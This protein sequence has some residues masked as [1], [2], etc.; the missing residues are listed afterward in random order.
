M[1]WVLMKTSIRVF[2]LSFFRVLKPHIT[3]LRRFEPRIDFFNLLSI[4]FIRAF[5]SA[6][7]NKW[8]LSIRNIHFFVSQSLSAQTLFWLIL[9]S[10]GWNDGRIT[11]HFVLFWFPRNVFSC[12]E[13]IG[14]YCRDI[15][16]KSET[17]SSLFFMDITL[18]NFYIFEWFELFLYTFFEYSWFLKLI[19]FKGGSRFLDFCLSWSFLSNNVYKINLK[20]ISLSEWFESIQSFPSRQRNWFQ[21]G[22]A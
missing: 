5:F 10:T 17:Y 21:D 20:F 11:I 4:V 14:K 13:C 3:Y 18:A 7:N 15:C 16:E 12:H 9:V 8:I 19:R 1:L 22:I 6:L 2:F